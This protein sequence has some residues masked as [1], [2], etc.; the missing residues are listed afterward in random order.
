MSLQVLSP[1]PMTTVQDRGRFGYI[2]LGIGPSGAMDQAAYAAANRLVGNRHGE[3]V[4]EATL[5]GPTLKFEEDCLCA[6]T[7]ADMDA[8][9]EGQPVEPYRSFLVRAGQTLALGFART[10]CRGYMAVKGGIQVPEV[11][12][13]RSTNLK[14][15]LGGLEGRKLRAGDRL[16][17]T[18]TPKNSRERREIP[19]FYEQSV[20]LRVIPG[21]QAGAF[22]DG[23]FHTLWNTA[24]TMSP[25]SDRM[26]LRLEGAVIETRA[27][28]DIV[29]DGIA[30]GAI[31][32][33]SAGQ[34]IL[35][36]ADRQT[37]G[38]YAKIGTVITADLPK[39]AQLKPGATIRFQPI[40]VEEA[41]KLIRKRRALL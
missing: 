16:P 7:G 4:L 34:P 1:G 22:T 13:S 26:G 31:Q 9:L 28:S 38:G 3:A 5:L 36:M 40:T 17:V 11:M 2:A 10:G 20:T 6:L 30:L 15:A 35:L 24:F 12:G 27:G 37:T 21:P 18:N 23:G 33:T 29:S 14:C 19:A 41:Q 25:N 32:V 39:A 8:K